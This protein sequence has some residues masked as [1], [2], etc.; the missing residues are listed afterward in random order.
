MNN[1]ENNRRNNRA[2]R[3]GNVHVYHRSPILERVRTQVRW[4]WYKI[5]RYTRPDDRPRGGCFTES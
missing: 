1:R 3:R 5:E 2:W 4:P